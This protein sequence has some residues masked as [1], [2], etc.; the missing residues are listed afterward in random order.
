MDRP[1]RV[2]A[3][4]D[5]L[6]PRS[7]TVVDV[8]AGDGFTAEALSTH[9][10]VVALEP[11][12]G[13]RRGDRPLAWLA[14]VAQAVPLRTASVTAA[15]STWAYFFTGPGWD[16][17]PGVTELHRVVRAGGPLVVVDNL[18]GD[19]FTA[20][21][22]SPAPAADVD[23]WATM[24]FDC[25]VVETVFEFDNERDARELL[26]LYFGALD[27]DRIALTYSYRVG[28]FTTDSRGASKGP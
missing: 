5:E 1:G 26:T 13:M 6:L 18:G 14:G 24:G 20:L 15:Y 16:P 12:A 25:Q 10:E 23:Q 3:A 9:R 8:G 4:L 22:Q 27:V 2:I 7:A 19:E 11:A 17:T 21:A 28:I